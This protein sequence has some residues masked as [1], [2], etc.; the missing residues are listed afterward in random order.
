M[1]FGIRLWNWT[2][3][4]DFGIG[5][6]TWTWIVTTIYQLS[7]PFLFFASNFIDGFIFK[8]EAVGSNYNDSVSASFAGNCVNFYNF[9]IIVVC[10]GK[11]FSIIITHE[12][13]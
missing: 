5:L 2:L 1:D 8:L 4:L 10:S 7:S 11:L 9:N 6:W 12:N 13:K 3:E